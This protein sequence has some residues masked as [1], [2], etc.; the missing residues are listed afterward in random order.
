[1]DPTSLSDL[2][3]ASS[4]CEGRL[5]YF[6][7]QAAGTEQWCQAEYG[8]DLLPWAIKA[9]L[10]WSLQRCKSAQNRGLHFCNAQK[11]KSSWKCWILLIT[12]EPKK[13]KL[14]LCLPPGWHFKWKK[15]KQAIFQIR[16]SELKPEQEVPKQL[17]QQLAFIEEISSYEF[18][19]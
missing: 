17:L 2:R 10:Q 8:T 19:F 12:K 15:S 7:L 13:S 5:E 11:M 3:V 6:T 1:M 16:L 9:M 4:G 18:H 14:Q